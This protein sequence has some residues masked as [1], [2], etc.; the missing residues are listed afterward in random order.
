MARSLNNFITLDQ[1]FKGDHPLLEQSYSPMTIRFFLLQAH[2]RGTVD[3]SNEALQAAEKGKQKLMKAIETLGK[4]KPSLSSSV[5]IASL[6]TKCYEAMDDDLNSPVL[7]SHLFEGVRYVN[8]VS[9]GTEKLTMNDIKVL[10][11]LFE[12]FVFEILG[13]KDEEETGSSDRLTD[14]L[15]K[16]I[17]DLRQ[18][19]KNNKEW[20]VSDKIREELKGAG[21][22]LKDTKDG[23]EWER[24]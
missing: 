24:I 12:I 3:F 9:D 15:M 20:A 19:A 21:I 4:L 13:L 18:N 16:I 17:I 11:E 10:K 8:S 5:D 23:A 14:D 7:L 6:K 22:V 2:Y 1:L